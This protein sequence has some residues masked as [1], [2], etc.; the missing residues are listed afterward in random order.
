MDH[1]PFH[2][3]PQLAHLAHLSYAMIALAAKVFSVIPADVAVR[4]A[5]SYIVANVFTIPATTCGPK[6][7]PRCVTEQPLGLST[8][9]LVME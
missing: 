6:N 5:T 3:S 8:E 9:V 7:C 1:D 4:K 2:E